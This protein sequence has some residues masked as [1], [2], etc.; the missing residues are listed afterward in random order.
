MAFS[1]TS[2][3]RFFGDAP[4]PL[5]TPADAASEDE[6]EGCGAALSLSPAPPLL[7]RVTDSAAV[8]P[9]PFPRTWRGSGWYRRICLGATALPRRGGLR[10]I[11][12]TPPT[13]GTAGRAALLRA[14]KDR[15]AREAAARMGL[16]ARACAV[17]AR[18]LE[19]PCR[20]EGR[21]LTSPATEA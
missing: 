6:N 19:P 1:T 14:L 12:S 7:G 17:T 18:E 16:E 3:S 11:A 21:A 20:I 8:S 2:E 13:R 15:D 5:R 9:P 10:S 4:P